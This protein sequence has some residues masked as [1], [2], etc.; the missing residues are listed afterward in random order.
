VGTKVDVL[1]DVSEA[2]PNGSGGVTVTSRV[3]ISVTM[4]T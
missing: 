3:Q 4:F 2:D 1:G